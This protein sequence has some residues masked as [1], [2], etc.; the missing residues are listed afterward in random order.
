M[1]KHKTSVWYPEEHDTKLAKTF[2][3]EQYQKEVELKGYNMAKR[4]RIGVV[5]DRSRPQSPA[6]ITTS[7]VKRN[8]YRVIVEG[9]IRPKTRPE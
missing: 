9:D 7:S 1:L 6:F 8:G 3:F 5:W 2:A 4:P